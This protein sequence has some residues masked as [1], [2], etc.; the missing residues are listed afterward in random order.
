MTTRLI[1]AGL[2]I[3]GVLGCGGDRNTTLH[4]HR[5]GPGVRPTTAREG[6]EVRVT[7]F[8]AH[9]RKTGADVPIDL[10]ALDPD[11]LLFAPNMPV[12][13]PHEITLRVHDVDAKGEHRYDVLLGPYYPR[14]EFGVGEV[15]TTTATASVQVGYVVVIGKLP[16]AQSRWVDTS[17]DTTQWGIWIEPGEGGRGERHLVFNLEPSNSTA[18]VYVNLRQAPHP[19]PEQLRHDEFIEATATTL[20]RHKLPDWRADYMLQRARLA[21]LPVQTTAAHPGAPGR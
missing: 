8:I 18:V 16:L 6:A 4:P 13:L 20:T 10:R 7:G 12:R 9:D 21:A 15:H 5:P 11:G 2:C 19:K 3:S 17:S 1:L 14:E